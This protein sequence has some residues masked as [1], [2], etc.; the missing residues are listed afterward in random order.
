MPESHDAYDL[1]RGSELLRQAAEACGRRLTPE[2][3][4][5]LGVGLAATTLAEMDGKEFAVRRIQQLLDR[6]GRAGSDDDW[7]EQFHNELAL[8]DAEGLLWPLYQRDDHGKMARTDV[9]VAEGFNAEAGYVL[10][11]AHLAIA[12]AVNHDEPEAIAPL[13]EIVGDLVEGS[14]ATDHLPRVRAALGFDQEEP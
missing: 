9:A 5:W 1:E 8:L 6:L 7:F 2:E 4:W 10:A 14:P 11:L 3:Y 13:A 12:R